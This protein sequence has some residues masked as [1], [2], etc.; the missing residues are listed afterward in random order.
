MQG[1]QLP[2]CQNNIRLLSGMITSRLFI[3]TQIKLPRD[4]DWPLAIATFAN[5]LR[6]TI[7]CFALRTL[8][9]MSPQGSYSLRAV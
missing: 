8:V 6:A 2:F 3:L 1:V 7:W 4:Y 5:A 9:S